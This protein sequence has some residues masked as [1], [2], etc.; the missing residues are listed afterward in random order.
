MNVHLYPGRAVAAIAAAVLLV[1]TSTPA[2]AAT[3][4]EASSVSRTV[5]SGTWGAAATLNTTAP[6]GTGPLT[7][8]FTN[9][10]S[11]GQPS[12]TPQ[13]FT[14]GNTGTLPLTQASYTG[15]PDA[16][17][18]VKFIVESCSTTWNESTGVC[19]NGTTTQIL[20]AQGGSPAVPVTSTTVPANAGGSIRLRA[21]VTTSGQIPNHS[22]TTLTID[23]TVNRTQVRSATTT[24]S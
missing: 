4:A 23:V 24:G 17:S 12:F 22:T 20:A 19:Q 3:A 7:L 14:V 13:Y 9:I 11:P 8:T 21:R 2:E 16:P 15:T 1:C 6:Y 18:A 5:G 10:G